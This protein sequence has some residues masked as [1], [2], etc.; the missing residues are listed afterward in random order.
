MDIWVPR[1]DKE[2]SKSITEDVS[3]ALA[4]HDRFFSMIAE[5]EMLLNE[6]LKPYGAPPSPLDVGK[7][8]VN[9]TEVTRKDF[10]SPDGPQRFDADFFRTEYSEL[11]EHC[12][13]LGT[14]AYLG[15]SFDLA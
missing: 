6:F 15:E 11:D 12:R 7:H 9:W 4:C 1:P 8:R 13:L 5:R 3:N 10:F 14:S 2:L